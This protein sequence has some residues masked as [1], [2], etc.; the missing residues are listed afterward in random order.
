MALIAHGTELARHLHFCS[1]YGLRSSA[2]QHSCRLGFIRLLTP[3]STKSLPSIHRSS[4]LKGTE[5]TN[6]CT[7]EQHEGQQMEKMGHHKEQ[8]LPP[9]PIKHTRRKLCR[10]FRE[11]WSRPRATVKA[12][13]KY[14]SRACALSQEKKTS[15]PG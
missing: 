1:E 12:L 10:V 3:R 4:L 5:I 2:S 8:D 9:K 7:V 13:Q 14:R 15:N 11:I 6:W